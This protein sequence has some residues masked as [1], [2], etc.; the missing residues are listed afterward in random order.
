MTV[1]S[2]LY[3]FPMFIRCS[4]PCVCF[5][6][7]SLYHLFSFI[8]YAWLCFGSGKGDPQDPVLCSRGRGGLSIWKLGHCPRARGQ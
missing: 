8:W 1:V 3:T 2:C 5:F 6:L 4:S 7:I